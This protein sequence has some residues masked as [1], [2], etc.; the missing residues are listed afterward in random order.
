MSIIKVPSG[1]GYERQQGI[2]RFVPQR[3]SAFSVA[4]P[5]T[6]LSAPPNNAEI[7]S[8]SINLSCK[9]GFFLSDYLI[10]RK[11]VPP[12]DSL[13]AGLELHLLFG[14]H[15]IPSPTPLSHK[16]RC[17]FSVTFQL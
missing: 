16:L 3:T 10:M 12:S 13:H 11:N 6:R 7:Q 1:D 14:A 17:D 4:S 2:C 9:I 5:K 15:N 8:L